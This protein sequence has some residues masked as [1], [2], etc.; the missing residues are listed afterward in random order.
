MMVD[1]IIGVFS[2]P[3]PTALPFVKAA[4]NA[5]HTIL[6]VFF[7][8]D[9]AYHL[10]GDWVMLNIPLLVCSTSAL[11]RGIT[12]D[13]L[14]SG[15]QLAGLGQFIQGLSQADRYIIFGHSS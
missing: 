10:N 4:Q 9:G 8:S 12:T 6:Q 7:Y 1:F 13:N 3:T 15:Y 14:H 2:H 5:G 11:T